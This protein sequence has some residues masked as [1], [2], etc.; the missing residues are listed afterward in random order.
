MFFLNI[1]MFHDLKVVVD[2]YAYRNILLNWWICDR[3]GGEGG[4]Y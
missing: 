3:K 4:G 1:R 2:S